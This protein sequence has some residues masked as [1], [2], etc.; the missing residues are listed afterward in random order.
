MARVL[1]VDDESLLRRLLERVLRDGGYD[2]VSARHGAEALSILADERVDVVV[3]DFMMPRMNGAELAMAMRE[4]LGD[5]APP[6]VLVSGT[7]DVVLPSQRELF[8]SVLG[9]PFTPAQLRDAVASSLRAARHAARSKTSGARLKAAADVPA[10]E[11]ADD[12]KTG[13]S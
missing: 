6:C 4:Q 12:A 10:E 2:V 13:E 1:V 11:D 9:K 7:I 3:T 5:A 8:A